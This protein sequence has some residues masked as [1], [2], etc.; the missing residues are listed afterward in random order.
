MSLTRKCGANCPLA[1]ILAG[2]FGHRARDWWY[3]NT[4]SDVRAERFLQRDQSGQPV[5]ESKMKTWHRL[6][7]FSDGKFLRGFL[8]G[9]ALLRI[10]GKHRK[11]NNEK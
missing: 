2:K 5:S 7:N 11:I 3:A 6:C 8:T 10:Y 9:L 4:A 1:G